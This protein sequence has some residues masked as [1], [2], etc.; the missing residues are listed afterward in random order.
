MVK[1]QTDHHNKSWRYIAIVISRVGE[2]K[3]W[4]SV[5][6]SLSADEAMAA[7][8]DKAAATMMQCNVPETKYIAPSLP[9]NVDAKASFSQ[10]NEVCRSL[11]CTWRW[12]W[13]DTA[14]LPHQR[15]KNNE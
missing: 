9:T 15:R 1:L 3:P 8:S 12:T 11:L 6:V 14:S 13:T 4:G 10:A 2:R 5:H 7:P